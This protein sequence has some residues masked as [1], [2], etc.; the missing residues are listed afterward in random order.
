VRG[1]SYFILLYRYPQDIARTLSEHEV[2]SI[3]PFVLPLSHCFSLLAL[4]TPLPPISHCSVT[5]PD[6]QSHADKI[7]SFETNGLQS[8]RSRLFSALGLWR[9]EII[10][11]GRKQLLFNLKIAAENSSETLVAI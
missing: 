2:Q 9:R 10:R 4:L 8:N 6:A 5:Q 11:T 7:M 3:L 1:T